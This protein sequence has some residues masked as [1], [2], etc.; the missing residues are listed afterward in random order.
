MNDTTNQTVEG[1]H[2]LGQLIC[3]SDREVEIVRLHLPEH[4]RLTR[5]EMGCISF[6]VTQTDDLLIWK[7][8]ERFQDR[9]SFELHQQRTRSSAWWAA[10]AEISRGFKVSG[11]D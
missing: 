6:D 2:L 11:L 7:V 5:A 8:E 4:I 9:K 1:V 3:E 10:T